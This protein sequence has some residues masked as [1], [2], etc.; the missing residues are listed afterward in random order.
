MINSTEYEDEMK[1]DKMSGKSVIKFPNN[2]RYEDN[3]ENDK[4]D[5]FGKKA[6][7]D[8]KLKMDILKMMN[9]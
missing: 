4:M 8:A 2:G 1:D 3:F 7:A 6:Y 9:I 5:E